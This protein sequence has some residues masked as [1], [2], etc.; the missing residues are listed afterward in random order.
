MN[1]FNI[2]LLLREPNSKATVDP[3]QKV[4]VLYV[5]T[6]MKV[7]FR[8]GLHIESIVLP[9]HNLQFHQKG[10]SAQHQKFCRVQLVTL[11]QSSA[12]LRVGQ[13]I[14]SIGAIMEKYWL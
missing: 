2:E 5:H 6:Y 12:V 8:Y 13:T 3:K 10:V 14:C 7:G 11:C 4:L 1:K 9:V